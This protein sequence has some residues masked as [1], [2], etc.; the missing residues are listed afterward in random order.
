MFTR[1]EIKDKVFIDYAHAKER[2]ELKEHDY[3]AFIQ[4]VLIRGFDDNMINSV[5]DNYSTFDLYEGIT[6]IIKHLPL[7]NLKMIEDYCVDE[8]GYTRHFNSYSEMY[9]ELS[10]IGVLKFRPKKDNVI[11]NIASKLSGK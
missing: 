7:S 5:N 6:N 9:N 8:N 4:I 11:A 1:E 10:N 2:A 3:R